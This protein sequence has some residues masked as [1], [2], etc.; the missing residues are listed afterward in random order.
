[1]KTGIIGCGTIGTLLANAI[2]KEIPQLKLMVLHDQ[3]KDKAR[4]LA[5]GL[6]TKPTLASDIEEVV[7]L[8]DLV[9]EAASPEI[10][11]N[12][13]RLIIEKKKD[14]MIMSVGGVLDC[15]ELLEKVER[16]GQSR[17]FFPSGAIAGLDG[18]NAARQ[19]NIQSVT[20]VT[21][22]PPQAFSDAPYVIQNQI[23]LNSITNPKVI[24]EGS[25]REAVKGF[26]KNINVSAILSLAGIGM[27]KTKVKIIADP[28]RIRN[29]HRIM[30]QG[31]FGDIEIKVENVPSPANPKTSMLAA[32][33]AIA[34]LKKIVNPVKIGT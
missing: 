19:G 4:K 16:F 32:L 34:T 17:V 28:S 1:M 6:H 14:L 21:S 22:K 18:L 2:D 11:G 5:E 26:P 33:S 10:V 7:E 13:L 23:D 27:D 24:F 9:V 12:L 29:T 30:I 15:L 8:S 31:D 3:D 25:C 20:L